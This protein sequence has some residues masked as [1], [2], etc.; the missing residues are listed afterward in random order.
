MRFFYHLP[1][2]AYYLNYLFFLPTDSLL[3]QGI[4]ASLFITANAKSLN[5][6]IKNTRE[7]GELYIN[8]D[9]Q[10][11]IAVLPKLLVSSNYNELKGKI[12][13]SI[14]EANDC[15][16]FQFGLDDIES[17]TL[18]SNDKDKIKTDLTEKFGKKGNTDS[19]A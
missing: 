17:I 12:K 3:H 2:F 11:Y 1:F 10:K 19:S 16:G 4:L 13:G 6:S 18:L 8:N 15:Q 5:D 14:Y 9:A 7:I